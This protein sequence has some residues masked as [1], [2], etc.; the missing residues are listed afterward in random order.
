VRFG[1]GH[2]APWIHKQ[3]GDTL[4]T[5]APDSFAFHTSAPLEIG[6]HD[7]RGV[8]KVKK[9][10]RTPFELAWYPVDE[11]PPEKLDSF[12][13]LDSTARTWTE[14]SERST[15]HGPHQD[16]VNQSLVALKAMIYEPS[17]GIVAAPTADLSTPARSRRTPSPASRS[18][19]DK[20]HASGSPSDRSK[21][22]DF[23]HLRTTHSRCAN[24]TRGCY[25]IS[26]RGTFS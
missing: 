23:H 24:V 25:P 22:L 9:G 4:L 6:E 2:Y 1:Y 26:S 3:N 12:R 18:V 10:E 5:T 17:G 21:E 15:Y 8:A 11:K 20:N 16:I 13:E 19:M 14:W 7:I